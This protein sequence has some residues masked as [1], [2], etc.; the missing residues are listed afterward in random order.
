MQHTILERTTIKHLTLRLV[1]FLF[2]LLLVN[3]LDRVNIGFAALHMNADLGLSATAFGFGASVFFIGYA[4]FEVPS[5]II[6][7]RVGARIWLARIMISWGIISGAMAFVQSEQWFIILRFLLGVAEGGFMPGIIFYL[8]AWFPLA[9]RSRA[10]SGVVAATAV[11]SVVGAPLSGFLLTSPPQLFGLVG[12]QWMFLLEAAPAVVLGIVLLFVLPESPARARWLASDQREWL[13]S[14]L[15]AED[16]ANPADDHLSL[17]KVARLPRVWV[18]AALFTCLLTALY[19]V[20]LWLPQIVHSLGKL[21][22]LQIGF[23][24]AIPFL[25]GAAAMLL[26]ARHSDRTGERLRH[27]AVPL[28]VGGASLLASAYSPNP[29]VAF[30]FL[31]IAAG[32]IWGGLG[33]FWTLAGEFLAGAARAKAI[34]LINTLAQMGGLIGPWMTGALKDATGGFAVP[35]TLLAVASFLAAAIALLM[36]RLPK[37]SLRPPMVPAKAYSPTTNSASSQKEPTA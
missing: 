6:L 33:V 15:K 24:S 1:P 4:L 28:A 26:I 8:S 11:A 14:T 17:W 20:L 19:G 32:G 16:D 25:C 37:T 2:L 9:H 29:V 21:T 23:L 36:N 12:W 5:N 31:T 18:L 7:Q 30:I 13:V 35:L 27:L 3:Y 22:D 10:N 34:A